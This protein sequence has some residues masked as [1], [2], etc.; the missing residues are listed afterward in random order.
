MSRAATVRTHCHQHAVLKGDADRELMRRS[1]LDAGC[2]G[3]AGNF[4]FERGHYEL[5]M[6]IGEQGVLPAVRDTAPGALVLADGF[7]C[8][9]QI[10]QGGTGRRALHLAE[11][12]ALGIDGPLPAHHP[13]RAA[14]RP[15]TR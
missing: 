11:A 12:L 6:K 9:T 10:E 14:D 1:G 4:G 13:E 5:S 8:R 7:S 2:C 3:L 15:S